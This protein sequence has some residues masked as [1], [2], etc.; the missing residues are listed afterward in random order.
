MDKLDSMQKKFE[1]FS[2]ERDWQ[3][4]HNPKDL[5]MKISIEAGELLELFEWKTSEESYRIAQERK[6]EVGQEAA[7]VLGL[8]LEFANI[9][10]IDLYEEFNRKMLI[11]EKKYPKDLVKGKNHKYTYYQEQ[12]TKNKN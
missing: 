4:F 3:K 10:G 5:A 6:D 8:L 11:N 2:R 9:T 12:E 1:E 7:D